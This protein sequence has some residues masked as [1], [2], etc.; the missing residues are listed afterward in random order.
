MV[1]LQGQCKQTLDTKISV[2]ISNLKTKIQFTNFLAMNLFVYK[3]YQNRESWGE[4]N[5]PTQV[6][7]V[8]FKLGKMLTFLTM[9]LVLKP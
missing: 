1:N 3:Y 8:R 9:K 5:Y 2:K 7:L 6:W 4:M